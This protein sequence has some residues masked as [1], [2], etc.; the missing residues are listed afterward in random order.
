MAVTVTL[1]VFS[2]RPDPEWTL[3]PHQTAGFKSRLAAL[4]NAAPHEFSEEPLGYRGLLVRDGRTSVKVFHGR[5]SRE[6]KVYA[7]KNRQFEKWLLDTGRGTVESDVAS[8]V[9][10]DISSGR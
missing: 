8:Y 10:E 6:G 3:T 4:S 7:D 5:V 9:N 1:E 2:G